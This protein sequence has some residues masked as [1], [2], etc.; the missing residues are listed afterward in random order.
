MIEPHSKPPTAT[1]ERG[2]APRETVREKEPFVWAVFM[3]IKAVFF[4]SDRGIVMGNTG[5]I[6]SFESFGTVDGPGIRFVVFMQGCPMRCLYCHNPDSRPMLGGRELS[7]E[8]TVNEA[9]K[10]KG[11]FGEKGGVTV[12][13]GEPLVQLDFLIELFTLLK[14]KGIHTCLDTS[15]ICFREE[16]GR[17]A[18][19]A[20]VTDLVL[21]DIKHADDE[22]H[23]ALTGKSG[24]APRAFAQFLSERGV[25]MWIRH[26][27]VPGLTDDDG[28]LARLRAFLDT[29]KTVER[30]EVL[31][32]HSMGEV[33]YERMGLFY[34]LH[35]TPS[36]TQERVEHARRILTG[37][38]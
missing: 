1:D 23:L 19:L 10:Y 26:V 9:L 27:L 21:L 8:E 5:K 30:V 29:L 20:R 35:G 36:P 3:G 7:A 31:P 13:G 24:S 16:D 25:P 32:Y 17:Y 34:P 28:A 15:G 37:K 4:F 38:V 18:A 14:G 12:S 6:H 22:A 33:K 11:Y 2:G